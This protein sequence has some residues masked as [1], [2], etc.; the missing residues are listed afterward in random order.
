[1]NQ[2]SWE[3][4]SDIIYRKDI[5]SIQIIS[6]IENS[7]SKEIL[8]LQYKYYYLNYCFLKIFMNPRKGYPCINRKKNVIKRYLSYSYNIYISLLIVRFCYKIEKSEGQVLLL[9]FNWKG[10]DEKICFKIQK[11]MRNIYPL[12]LHTFY[13]TNM[14]QSLMVLC[15]E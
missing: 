12:L 5:N 6:E 15:F 3:E 7:R 4:E 11:Y 14:I 10:V 8:F 13:L 2:A 1:M 9:Y